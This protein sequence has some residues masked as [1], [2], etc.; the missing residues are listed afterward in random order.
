MAKDLL[1]LCKGDEPTRVVACSRKVIEVDST[2]TALGEMEHTE[3]EGYAAL[4]VDP[5]NWAGERIRT[6]QLKEVMAYAAQK[7]MPVI[8][9]TREK[10]IDMARKRAFVS[11]F[12]VIKG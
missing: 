6:K 7:G 3:G 12:N 5:F 10:E 4:I 9:Y 1:M 11:I 2:E 8:L